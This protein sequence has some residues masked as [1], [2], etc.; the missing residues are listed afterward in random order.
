MISDANATGSAT[1]T[2]HG[3]TPRM[4][5]AARAL[6]EAIFSTEAGPPPPER[7]D[8][9][10]RELDDFLARVGS[11]TRLVLWL[12]VFAVS[13]LA[14]LL[15]FRLLPLRALPLPK[16]IDALERLE[17]SHA[18]MALLATKA[19]LSILYYEHP[20]AAREVGFDGACLKAGKEETA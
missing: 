15:S 11:R 20:D 1:A 17:R 8:W 13:W 18:A 12:S 5:R 14:P 16:R 10:V 2:I 7:L 3:A 9:L 19:I 4:L 6:A